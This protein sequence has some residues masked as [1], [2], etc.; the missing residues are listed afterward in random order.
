MGQNYSAL[1]DRNVGSAGIEITEL[2]DIH[3]ERSLGSARFLKTIRASHDDGLVVVKIFLKPSPTFSLAEYHSQIKH[4]QESLADIPNAISYQRIIETDKAGYMVRQYLYSS[5]Y[6]RIS[7]R[8]FLEEIEKRWVAFQL[9]CGLRDCHA[10]GIHHGD[11]KAENVLVTTW[12]WI[13][14]SDFA[15]FKPTHLPEDNPADFSYFFDTSGRRICYVAPERFLGAGERSSEA[16]LTDEMDIFSLGCVIAE[17]F[18][19]GTPLFTLSQL[20]KYRSGEY[21]P[22]THLEKIE[23]PDI[24]HMVQHMINLDP[25]KRHSAEQYLNLWRRKAF[26]EYFYSFLHQYI[27]FITDPTSGQGSLVA[28]D[29]RDLANQADD[30]ID[31]IYHDFDKIAFFLGFDQSQDT[32]SGGQEGRIASKD[33]IIP[34]HLD[35]PNYQRRS[36]AVRRR[37]I[38]SDDGTLIFLSLISSS[39]RNTSRATAR[40]RA[41][42]LFLAFAERCTDEAKMDRCLPHLVLLLQD[43][44][45]IVRV[46]ALRTVT[47]LMELVEVVSPVNAHVFPEYIHPKLDKF[48]DSDHIIIRSTY[49]SC[50]ASL[51]DSA[52][53][54]LDMAQALRASGA[55]PTADPEAEGDAPATESALFDVARADLVSFFSEHS[56]I[57]L[58]DPSSSVRRAFLRSVSRLCVFF[59]QNKAN[60]VILSHLN[61]YLNDKDWMLRCAFFETITGVATYIGGTALEEYIMPLMVQS[62]TDPEEFVVVKVLGSLTGMAEVG[63]LGRAKVWEC[64]EVVGRFMVHPNLWVR[65]GAAAFIAAGTKWLSPAD[66]HCIVAPMVRPFLKNDVVSLDALSILENLKKPLS[67]N[68]FDMAVTWATQTRRGIFW[69]AAQEQRTFA[70]GS[71]MEAFP[72][73]GV[74][75]VGVNMFMRVPKNEE[76]EN[77]LGKLRNLGMTAED[78]WK[79]IA[80]REYIWRMAQSKTQLISDD[81]PSV[82]NSTISLKNLNITPQTIFFDENESFF[83]LAADTSPPTG[84]RPHTIADALLDASKTID[85][86]RRSPSTRLKRPPGMEIRRSRL[87]GDSMSMSGSGPPTPTAETSAPLAVPVVTVA[88]SSESSTAAS[89]VDNSHNGPALLRRKPSTLSLLARGQEAGKAPPET[90]T[91]SVSAF[92]RVEHPFTRN[93]DGALKVTETV[94]T[95]VFKFRGAHSYDGNDP[96]ILK[97][98]DAMYLQNYP[99]DILEFGPA[100]VPIPTQQRR[101]PIKKSSGRPAGGTW[102]PEGVL[103]AQFGEHTGAINRVVVASDHNFFVTGSDDGTVKVWDSSRLEKNVAFKARQTYRHA[104]GSKVKALCFVENTRCFVSAATDGSVHVVKVDLQLTGQAAK[105]GKL[106]VMRNWQLPEKEYAVWM[107]H[108]KADTHSILLI[109]TNNSNIYGLDLRTMQILYTLKNPMFHG[110]LTCFCVDRKHNWLIVG[111]SHGLL[112]MWDLRFQ[113]RLKAWGLPGSAPIH[114]VSVHPSKGRGKWII[115]AGGTGHGEL[116]VWDCEK[117]QCREVY[118]AGGKDSGK[119]YEPWNVEEESSEKM[120][121]RFATT[122]THLESGGASNGDRGVRAFVAGLDVTED[123]GESR[124][125]P[126]FIISAGADKK[127]RFWNCT[128][129]ESSIVVSGLDAEELK[130]TFTT[131]HPTTTLTLNTERVPAPAGSTPEAA[132]SSGG[133]ALLP[134]A[135]GS[136][137]GKKAAKAS[138]RTPRS[139]VISMQQQQLLKCHLDSILD[140]AFLEV[141]YGMIISVDRSGVIFIYQ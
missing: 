128:K 27:G 93:G 33:S 138:G 25:S 49:A 84:N 101:T 21:D 18:L 44:S 129:V 82:L 22:A 127:I 48:V 121:A 102:K 1:P 120:L 89:S 55:L 35:I 97:L 38:S 104:T 92:G 62:L 108:F 141:P 112:D 37:P 115:V 122:P 12:N 107:E 125:M 85:A 40:V 7:T 36:S 13:Y 126:G 99:S 74:R 105:Y 71:V 31:R 65:Q 20:F 96:H 28:V 24:R 78:E 52:S 3:Y 39:V 88:G 15:R 134:G 79:V 116:S 47:Q 23:D 100:I 135:A 124:T 111:T 34:V 41:C 14:L 43:K 56:K 130:P 17:L 75:D 16:N 57:L 140:V 110:T 67:R 76:D 113:L 42:D 118:R 11:I 70:Y 106:K 46:A 139:T 109:A 63:L 54:F 123:S 53:R 61:T 2:S 114:R 132:S 4:E 10:R 19:E 59:G 137:T 131:S 50:L 58:T 51:A 73:A 77:W 90:G 94:E 87:G 9:L 81:T 86:P 117:T 83:S 98:L 30:R 6:D 29:E 5:L 8:P 72:K 60:D 26:P 80:L 136:S 91:V 45:V 69:N 68:V 133:R 64:C 95:P 66:V 119:G 32:N 103:V